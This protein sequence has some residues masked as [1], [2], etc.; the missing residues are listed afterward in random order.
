MDKLA[1]DL[2]WR[3]A[4]NFIPSGRIPSRP[5]NGSGKGLLLAAHVKIISPQRFIFPG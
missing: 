2:D 5:G 4:G 1:D 3:E